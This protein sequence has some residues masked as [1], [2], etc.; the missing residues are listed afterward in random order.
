MD[1]VRMAQERD[2]MW[3]FGTILINRLKLIHYYGAPQK[4]FQIIAIKVQS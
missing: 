2:Q 3:P 1:C 4:M